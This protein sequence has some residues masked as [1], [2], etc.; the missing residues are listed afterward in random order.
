M[1]LAGRESDYLKELL[2]KYPDVKYLGFTVPP[3]HLSIVKLADIG[4]LTYVADSGSIN[5]V[6]CAPNKI[7]EYAKYGIPMLC[8]DI[9]GLKYT[10]E[11]YR[12]WILFVDISIQ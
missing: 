5:P 1:V 6:F 4:I 9:P 8:N 2:I 10:V 3:K 7:W 11:Y 12:T